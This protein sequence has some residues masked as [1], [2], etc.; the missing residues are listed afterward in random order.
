MDA[1]SNCICH[2]MQ[3]MIIFSQWKNYRKKKKHCSKKLRY[4]RQQPGIQAY[5]SHSMC[6]M[7]VVENKKMKRETENNIKLIKMLSYTFH[8]FTMEWNEIELNYFHQ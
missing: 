1:N 3:I 8:A 5:G 2:K 6:Q 7:H 4:H